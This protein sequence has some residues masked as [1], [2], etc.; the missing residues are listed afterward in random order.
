M[1]GRLSIRCPDQPGVVAAVSSYMHRMGCN[2]VHL[3]QHAT[4]P[5]GHTLFMRLE[6]E[7]LA[8]T[9][10][11]AVRDGF[12]DVAFPLNM[13]WQLAGATARPKVGILASRTDHCLLELLWRWQRGELPCEIALVVSNHADLR[14]AVER[15]GVHFEHVPVSADSK[16][17]AEA[18]Q[19]ELLA[20]CDLLVLARYMQ[21]L[22]PEFVAQWPSRIIN[23]HHSFLPAFVGADPYRQAWERGV[24]LIGATAH[25]VTDDLD[26][27]PIIHQLVEP[28]THRESIADLRHLGQE[29]E[30]KALYQAVRWHLEDR[31][32]VHGRKTTVFR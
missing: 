2:I 11:D 25:Y 3:D 26:E 7:L 15:F 21:I 4:E 6:F 9:S 30:R 29:L 14:D 32:V 31:V 8:G 22:S 24:K 17:G 5:D 16:A 10:L 19:R 12:T 28:V 20:D 1:L 23:I 27:G 13:H 18:R